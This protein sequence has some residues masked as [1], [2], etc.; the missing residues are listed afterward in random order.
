MDIYPQLE[1]KY[2]LMPVITN[3]SKLKDNL[4]VK[5]GLAKPLFLI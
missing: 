2:N 1:V 4:A 3:I 5:F